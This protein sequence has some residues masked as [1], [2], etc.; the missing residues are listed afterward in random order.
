MNYEEIWTPIKYNDFNIETNS[1][2]KDTIKKLE[3]LDNTV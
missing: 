2:A 3:H 1:V